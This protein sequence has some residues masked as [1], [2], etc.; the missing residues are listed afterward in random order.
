[1]VEVSSWSFSSVI[2]VDS[3][4]AW[5]SELVGALGKHSRLFGQD[6]AFSLPVLAAVERL[7]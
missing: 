6:V 5:V 7:K 3:S 4:F 2:G 1:M